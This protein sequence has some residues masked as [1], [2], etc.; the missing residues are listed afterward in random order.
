MPVD[1]FRRHEAGVTESLPHR[2]RSP[3]KRRGK[4]G[5]RFC[6]VGSEGSADYIKSTALTVQIKAHTWYHWPLAPSCEKEPLYMPTARGRPTAVKTLRGTWSSSVLSRMNI[7]EVFEAGLRDE[8]GGDEE[9][10]S[11]GW[12]ERGHL[13]RGCFVM[14]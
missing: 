9:R 6:L 13:S 7:L 11:D 3:S 12:P 14:S 8:L 4:C 5:H 1:I 10:C 2:C